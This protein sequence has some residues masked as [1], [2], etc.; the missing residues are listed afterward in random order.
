M[1]V[2]RGNIVPADPEGLYH[3]HDP[4]LHQHIYSSFHLTAEQMQRYTAHME[5]VQP[6]FLH[7]YPS[8]AWTL[9]RFLLANGRRFPDSLQAILLESEPVYD[10]QRRFI[11][12]HFPI[13]VFSSY[14]HTEKVVLAAESEQ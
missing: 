13:R 1:A 8:S 2:L 11:T 14:G 7:A 10:H 5:S 6:R 3:A 12:E 9:A 4:L